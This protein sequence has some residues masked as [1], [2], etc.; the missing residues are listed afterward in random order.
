MDISSFF[1]QVGKAGK[2]RVWP[3]RCDAAIAAARERIARNFVL[4][5][6]LLILEVWS[7]E[8]AKP[9]LRREKGGHA[10]CTYK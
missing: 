5:E 3:D 4:R 2:G 6:T 9:V 7:D 1:Y 10:L 8:P